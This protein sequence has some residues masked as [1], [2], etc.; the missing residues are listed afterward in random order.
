MWK[1]RNNITLSLI[2]WTLTTSDV[3]VIKHRT[4]NEIDFFSDHIPIE[5]QVKIN[6]EQKEI[7][8]EI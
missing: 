8:N 7:R 1:N 2:D 4:L 5:V 6:Y 3:E